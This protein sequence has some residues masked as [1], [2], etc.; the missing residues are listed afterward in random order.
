MCRLF[1]SRGQVE[2]FVT[3]L[4]GY[5]R[6]YVAFKGHLRDFLISLKEFAGSDLMLDEREAE[7]ARVKNERDGRDKMIPGMVKPSDLMDD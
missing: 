4:F 1:I 5:S 2:A 3:G 7:V 6:D